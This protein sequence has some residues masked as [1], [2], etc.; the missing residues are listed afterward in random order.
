MGCPVHV[1]RGEWEFP[2][3]VNEFV[4]RMARGWSEANTALSKAQAEYKLYYNRRRTAAPEFKVGDRVW[5]NVSDIKT[6]RP[7]SKLAH[8]RLGP[9]PVTQ[10]ISPRAYKLGLNDSKI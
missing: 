9:F 1:T 3:Q 10:I 7:S 4:D 8:H 2:L 5:L 6:T